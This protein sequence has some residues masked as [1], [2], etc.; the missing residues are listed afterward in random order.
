MVQPVHVYLADVK[1]EQTGPRTS[2][3]APSFT[4]G[5]GGG[6]NGSHKYCNSLPICCKCRAVPSDGSFPPSVASVASVASVPFVAFV[7]FVAFVRAE[8]AGTQ[9]P[10]RIV[11]S[12][13]S[14]MSN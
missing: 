5:G 10:R 14:A 6:V 3:N 1:E 9:F 13:R 8:A 12:I 2:G 7:A 4:S 11:K